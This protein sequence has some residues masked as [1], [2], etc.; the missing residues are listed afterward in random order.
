M[1]DAGKL[2]E[3]PVAGEGERE[4][5]HDIAASEEVRLAR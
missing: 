5:D 4:P 2:E 1:S 3:K